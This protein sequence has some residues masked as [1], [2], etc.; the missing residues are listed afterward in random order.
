MK[1]KKNIYLPWPRPR[2]SILED[3]IAYGI[4]Y[5]ICMMKEKQMIDVHP[6]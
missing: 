3:T 4:L 6:F 5:V 1:T 2:G